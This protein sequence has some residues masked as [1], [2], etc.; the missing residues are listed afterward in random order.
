MHVKQIVN[1][2]SLM[3]LFARTKKPLTARD[4]VEEFS[5]PRSSAFNII[6]TLMDHGYLHQPSSRGAYSPTTKWMDLARE[7][8]DPDARPASVSDLLVE[9]MHRTGETMILAGAEGVSTVF[10]DVAETRE[11][12]RYSAD[13]GQ[14]LPIHVTAAGRAIMA[15]YAEEERAAV[16]GRIKYERYE[17]GA[18]MSPGA[19]AREIS[20]GAKRGWHVNLASYAYGVAGIA[21][22]FPFR[23]HRNAIV[24]G[25]PV[26]RVEDRVDELGA[27]LR[28]AVDKF[29]KKYR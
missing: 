17:K 19:V 2:F 1:L 18:P 23:N 25:A 9:L 16:L 22:P 4:I 27:L 26:S 5:W 15:Q 29:L 12:V 3:E 21:V 24:L 20:K 13:V 7:F 11:H 6:S 28:S 8:S 10:L 14:R